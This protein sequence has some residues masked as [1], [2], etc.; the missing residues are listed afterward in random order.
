MFDFLKNFI[1]NYLYTQMFG[2]NIC[3]NLTLVNKKE[4]ACDYKGQHFM[5]FMKQL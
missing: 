2:V 3:Y 5:I 1:D 4:K